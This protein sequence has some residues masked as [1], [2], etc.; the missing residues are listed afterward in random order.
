MAGH[1]VPF[2]TTNYGL[3]TTPENE[4]R[5]TKGTAKCQERNMLDKKGNK[6]RI[7]KTLDELKALKLAQK[8]KLGELEIIVVVR[9]PAGIILSCTNF[10]LSRNRSHGLLP[11]ALAGAL[12]RPHVPGPS[13]GIRKKPLQP[14]SCPPPPPD[15]ASSVAV[16]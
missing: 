12:H 9:G 13:R 1:D 10:A 11:A 3:T 4:F 6:V 8:A 2:T 5:I 7:I 15:T 14:P 16:G